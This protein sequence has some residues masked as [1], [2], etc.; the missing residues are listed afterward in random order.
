MRE[1]IYVA[2]NAQTLLKKYY[3]YSSFREGQEGIIK[4]ITGGNDTLA[5]MPTGAGKSICFQIPALIFDGLTLV[6]SPLISL[7]KDQV[8]T[9]DSIGIP[10]AFINSTLNYREVNERLDRAKKGQYKILYIAPERL[11]S[12]EFCSHIRDMNV[13]FAAI[14]EAHCVSQWGHDF[15]PSYKLIGKLLNRF[16]KRPVVAGFTATATE[17][18][19][20]DIVRLLSLNNANVFVTGFD[21]KNLYFSV[22]RDE[23]KN[24]FIQKYVEDNRDRSGIIYTATR[25][26][27]DNLCGMLCSMGFPAGKY[28]AGL[29]EE[30][31]TSFQEA[32]LYDDIK[33]MVATNAFGM[34]IDKSNVRYVVHY[35]MPKNMESYYQE[36]GR[37]G[38][39][40]EPSECILLF[41]PQDIMLQKFLIEKST[42]S[43]ERMANEFKKLQTMVDYCH[44][45]R[46]LRKFILE[47]FGEADVPEECGNC[48]S[49]RSDVELSDVTI[50]AQKIFSC[51]LRMKE[52]YGLTL[53]AD[54]LK[55]SKNR[56]VMECNFN[57][58]S[59]YGIMKEYSVKE[60]KDLINLFIS[61]DYIS[62]SGTEYPVLRLKPKAGPVLK[63]TEKVF[64]RITVRKQRFEEDGSLFEV[65]RAKRRSIAEREKMPPYVIFSD[66]TL[67]EMSAI[68]PTDKES[69]LLIKGVGEAKLKKYGEEFI[70]TIKEYL[71]EKGGELPE[72]GTPVYGSPEN[73]EKVPS[74]IISLNMYKEGLN[75]REIAKM[76]E[77]KEVTIQDHL[78]RCFKEG[79][80]VDLSSFIPEKYEQ[81]ILQKIRELGTQK[82]KPIKD[83]LPEDIDYMAIKAAMCKFS[84]LA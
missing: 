47:Y 53:V 60:I 67:R 35:N 8:D 18:V 25:R 13:S 31:R 70:S 20:Q 81:L 33:I 62:L 57:K 51:I 50:E 45:P 21:R 43:P 30:E 9:L 74:H 11:E 1:G 4:S 27:A 73:E 69:M 75:I 65:L 79:L 42:F 54:V 72:N 38:R 63:G 19:K 28:H 10:G 64:Q 49:C 76:R 7:M 59:T 41:S 29:S 36:A 83:A 68:C 12:E 46:C 34:G 32:F 24:D 48:G 52:R 16:D 80:P 6:I 82:L 37:A 58:L 14:D 61:E 66:S 39:D 23:N 84:L 15:R 56:R 55:G 3:G 71:K 17:E 5:I 22:V 2:E 77:M 40:G 26:E 44:T 78:I